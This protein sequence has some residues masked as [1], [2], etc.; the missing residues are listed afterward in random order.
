MEIKGLWYIEE[1]TESNLNHFTLAEVT[2]LFLIYL[3][4]KGIFL[5]M[6]SE[7]TINL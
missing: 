1:L 4:E 2:N 7:V 3:L 5:L 6:L